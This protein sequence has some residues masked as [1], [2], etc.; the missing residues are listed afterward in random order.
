MTLT[1]RS[2]ITTVPSTTGIILLAQGQSR[3]ASSVNNLKFKIIL[4]SLFFFT[5]GS[6]SR[7]QLV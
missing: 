4:N 5:N 7:P 1:D 2:A 6:Y 3:A